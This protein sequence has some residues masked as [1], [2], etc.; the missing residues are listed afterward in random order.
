MKIIKG[1]IQLADAFIKKHFDRILDWSVGDV[2]RACGMNVDGTCEEN[3]PLVGTFILWCCAIEY[4]GGLYTGL[5]D[6]GNTKR[7]FQGFIEKYMSRY[8]SK[9][10]EDLRWSLTHY[11]S[12]HHFVLYHEGNLE[13]NKSVHLSKKTIG[14]MLHLGWAITDLESAARNYHSDLKRDDVLKVKVWRFYKKQL[15][16]MPIDIGKLALS[17]QTNVSLATGSAIQS[18]KASGTIDPHQW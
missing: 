12:P 17:T 10:V 8:E 14:I 18:F 7:R 3:R 9:K 2:R 6:T 1:E 4:L 11:Y 5:S 15:P 16:I 13:N